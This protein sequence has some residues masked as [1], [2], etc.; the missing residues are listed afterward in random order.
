ML[1]AQKFG[2]H[3]PPLPLR[4]YRPDFNV[5]PDIFT[6]MNCSFLGDR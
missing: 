4:V 5:L 2:E 1:G 6:V 3:C